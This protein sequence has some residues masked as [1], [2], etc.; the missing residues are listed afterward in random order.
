MYALWVAVGILCWMGALCYAELGSRFQESGEMSFTYESLYGDRVA[1][2]MG[3]VIFAGIFTG[4]IAALAVPLCQFHCRAARRYCI[5]RLG[6][7]I[8]GGL[9]SDILACASC[10]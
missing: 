3:W 5:H 8:F 1:H 4:S 9:H 2:V 6:E 10:I 7:S